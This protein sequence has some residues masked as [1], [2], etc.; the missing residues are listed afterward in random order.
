[1]PWPGTREV[2]LSYGEIILNQDIDISSGNAAEGIAEKEVEKS[3]EKIDYAQ[4]ASGILKRLPSTLED[5][6]ELR[7]AIFHDPET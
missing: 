6:H 7:A 4:I 5:I 1:V 3:Q 2:I